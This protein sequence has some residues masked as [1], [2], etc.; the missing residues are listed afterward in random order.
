MGLVVVSP[1]A[2]RDMTTLV[3]V[4]RELGLAEEGEDLLLA[5]LIA[6]ASSAIEAE[7]RRRFVREGVVETAI[8]RGRALLMLT[9]T[10]IV[11]VESVMVD[12]VTLDA[13]AWQVISPDAGLVFRR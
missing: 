12:G 1:A 11:A 9:L 6:Q 5:D 4:K 10:P 7:C 13:A 8:G 3:S 2:T